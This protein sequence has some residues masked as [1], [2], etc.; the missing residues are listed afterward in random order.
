[1]IQ[2]MKNHESAISRFTYQE[3]HETHE[4]E[5]L[6]LSHFITLYLEESDARNLHYGIAE[7]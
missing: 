3:N 7:H 4:K 6:T 1:M 5:S 2:P